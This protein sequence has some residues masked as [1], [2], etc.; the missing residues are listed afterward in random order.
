MY[1]IKK[2]L[3]HFKENKITDQRIFLNRRKV[4]LGLMGSIFSAN[5]NNLY[6][7]SDKNNYNKVIKRN[8]TSFENISKYNNFFEFG[9]TKQ[10]WK[11]AQKLKTENW[12]IEI[13]GSNIS[14]TGVVPESSYS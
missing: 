8:L 3:L 6:A 7:N 12:K 11:Q 1:L 5:C 13:S 4:I 2:K 9:T 10:I 14:G